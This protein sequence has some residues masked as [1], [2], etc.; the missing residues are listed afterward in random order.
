MDINSLNQ[1]S[2]WSVATILFFSIAA[3]ALL[4][5]F[6]GRK[7]FEK[8]FGVWTDRGVVSSISLIVLGAFGLM[9]LISIVNDDYKVLNDSF[10]EKLS[11]DYGLKTDSTEYTVEQAAQDHRSL[12]MTT[13]DG[14]EVYIQPYRDGDVLTFYKVDRGE[15]ITPRK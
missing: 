13:E 5:V 4:S 8:I 15:P 2:T 7:I 3:I 6:F 11:A 12:L 9:G 10:H 1:S 14:K